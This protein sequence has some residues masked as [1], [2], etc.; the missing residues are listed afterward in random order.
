MENVCPVPS[1]EKLE[2]GSK[3]RRKS[4]FSSTE[5]IYKKKHIGHQ[6]KEGWSV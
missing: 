1:L 4:G 2:R 5:S 3:E 6:E